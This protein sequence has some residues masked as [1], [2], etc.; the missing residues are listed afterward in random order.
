M[1]FV[2]GRILTDWQA[3]TLGS[4]QRN[5]TR[6]RVGEQNLTV[7]VADTPAQIEQGLSDRSEI[8]SDGMLF[9]LPRRSQNSFWMLRMQF[10][11]DILWLDGG[12]IVQIDADV[13][14]PSETDGVPQV[15]PVVQPVEAVL[16]VPSGTA[17]RYG[18]TVGTP[19][20]VQ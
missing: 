12:R 19:W 5:Q 20:Q 18:W 16:E 10:A 1:I 7:E 8:G 3:G 14:P 17:A 13:P 6:I 11:L 9:V 4:L 2:L 15:V